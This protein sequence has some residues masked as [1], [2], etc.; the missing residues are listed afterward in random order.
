MQP[1][2]LCGFMGCG[3][4]VT[5]SE[6]SKR[7]NCRSYDLDDYI[8]LKEN[9]SVPDIFKTYGEAYFRKK[10]AFYIKELS[11]NR[12]VIALGGGAILNPQTAK[13]ANSCGI[14]IFL[15]VPF[16]VCYSRIKG[17][18]NRPLVVNNTKEQLQEIYNERKDIYQ[19]ICK[20]TVSSTETAEKVSEKIIDLIF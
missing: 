12:G 16:D 20:F 7:L 8:V 14:T 6:L 19:K 9:M 13:I 15:D 5:S 3:K 10:E 1:I 2:F 11:R 18:T 17:D 4:S